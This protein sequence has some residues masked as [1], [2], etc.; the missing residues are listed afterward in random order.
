M[1]K[2]GL[3]ALGVTGEQAD[4]VLEQHTAELTA[5]QQ[6]TTEAETKLSAAE[7]SISE[8]TEK[9]KA[10]DG[11]DVEGLKQT[12]A[13]WEKKYNDDTAALKMDKALEVALIGA[14]AVDIDIAKGQIDKETLKFGDDGKLVGLQEQLDNLKSNKSF[15][16]DSGETDPAATV[17]TGLEHGTGTSGDDQSTLRSAM[18]L[19]AA[20]KEDK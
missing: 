20:K 3:I 9:V 5:E 18:G 12:A 14:K 8:L 1:T 2:E 17:T 7:T 6:K 15:L 16:F 4:K 11:E 13:D 10:F 19:P